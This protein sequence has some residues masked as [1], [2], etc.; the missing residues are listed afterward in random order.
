MDDFSLDSA[1]RDSLRALPVPEPSPEFD[2]R[3]LAALSTPPSQ[4]LRFWEPARPL[5]LG[6]SC[7]LAVTLFALHW[8]LSAPLTVPLPSTAPPALASAPHPM[9]S[10][11]A[12]LDRPNLSAGCLADV[13]AAP[14]PAPPNRRPEPPRHAQMGRPMCLI[15]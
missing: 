8:T 13:W 2:S 3:V 1:L 7:S 4:W 11:D 14:P 12:L 15:V 6:V 5:L 10:L 9:P